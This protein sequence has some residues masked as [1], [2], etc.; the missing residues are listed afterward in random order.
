LYRY[1]EYLQQVIEAM[2]TETIRQHTHSNEMNEESDEDREEILDVLANIDMDEFTSIEQPD[3]KSE[4]KYFQK[5]L[6]SVDQANRFIHIHSK[7]FILRE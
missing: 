6:Q 3:M 1:N 4:E 7:T 2:Q 5:T